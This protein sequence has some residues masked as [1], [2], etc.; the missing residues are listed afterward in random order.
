MGVLHSRWSVLS[1]SVETYMANFMILLNYSGLEEWFVTFIQFHGPK[2]YRSSFLLF[3]ILFKMSANHLYHS[4][5]RVDLMLNLGCIAVMQC[6]DTNYLFMGDYVDRGYYSVETATVRIIA[7]LSCCKWFFSGVWNCTEWLESEF[8]NSFPVI[9]IP[10][11]CSVKPGFHSH[12][13]SL[14]VLWFWCCTRVTFFAVYVG[15]SVAGGL[16]G[17]VSW[18]YYHFAWKSWK[19][20][21]MTHCYQAT[22]THCYFWRGLLFHVVFFCF[23]CLLLLLYNSQIL[24]GRLQV[25]ADIL[26]VGYR[27]LKYM[28][29]TM[30]VFE[31][32][33]ENICFVVV[34][35]FLL[36]FCAFI[37]SNSSHLWDLVYD[38]PS[39]GSKLKYPEVNGHYL[40]Q[41]LVVF[42]LKWPPPMVRFSDLMD[43]MHNDED[44]K[45]ILWCL[46]QQW[47]SRGAHV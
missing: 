43:D 11:A 10:S 35:W 31:S 41:I 7:Y 25:D 29:S 26:V 37:W 34:K 23:W 18:S 12:W 38:A 16:K 4:L 6:P 17:A 19:S 22:A 28:A 14:C 45:D 1:Q 15:C 8:V 42:R 44:L 33:F 5:I 24:I 2:T 30:S 21:G 47:S 9:Q 27:L 3:E 36:I 20:T 32:E 40:D 39:D 46:V 13:F